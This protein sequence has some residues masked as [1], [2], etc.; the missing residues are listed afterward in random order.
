[1][2]IVTQTES[3]WQDDF[4]VT[5]ESET[6][7]QEYFMQQNRPLDSGELTRFLMEQ[8]IE[9]RMSNVQAGNGSYSPTGR[10]EVGERLLFPALEGVVGNVQSIREGQ[11]ERY[12]SF[13]VLQIGFAGR[14]NVREFA[15]ELSS[16]E[17]QLLQS[18]DEPLVST[19]EVVV[20]FG[21]H[22]QEKVEAALEASN[23][24]VQDGVQWLPQFMLVN[25][26]EGH[27]NI[28]EAMIDITGEPMP[29]GELLKE[30][31]LTEEAG[32]EVK[33]FSLNYALARDPR[34]KNVGDSQA[35]L[36]YLPRLG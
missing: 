33:E 21:P 30:L 14:D 34:F 19:E 31:P 27:A 8:E 26:H 29:P 10:Y 7:L 11:N 24:F 15:A 35:P 20:R 25:F 18:P 6:S 2:P 23:N 17:A 28:A 9:Q 22:V 13:R 36:W 5:A 16:Q 1:M 12:G 32:K 4:N 3:F